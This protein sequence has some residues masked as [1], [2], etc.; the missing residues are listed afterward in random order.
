[1][2]TLAVAS[3]PKVAGASL[4]GDLNDGTFETYPQRRGIRL[5]NSVS[6]VPQRLRSRST[7]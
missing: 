6:I 7:S 2:S 4:A 1:M 3:N 5:T